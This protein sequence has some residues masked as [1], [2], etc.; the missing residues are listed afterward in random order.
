MIVFYF[1]VILITHVFLRL[2]GLLGFSLGL[3]GFGL[4][5]GLFGLGLGL[6]GLSLGFFLKDIR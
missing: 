1:N 3:L 5:L 2:L 6:F 4:G